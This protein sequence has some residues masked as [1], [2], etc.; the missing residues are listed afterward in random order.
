MYVLRLLQIGEEPKRY[1]FA[2]TLEGYDKSQTATVSFEFQLTPQDQ[3]DL[4]WYLEDYLQ[5]PLD[6]ARKIAA[7]I[8]IFMRAIGAELFKAVFQTNDD[9]RTLW[10]KCRESLSDTRIEILLKGQE[11]I[12]LP[13]ELLSDA[14]TGTRLALQA[15]SFVRVN[16]LAEN[17]LLPSTDSTSIRILLVICRPAADDDVPFRSVA[18]HMLRG[19]SEKAKAHFQLDVLRPATFERLEQV[20]QSKKEAGTPYH[21]VHFDGH[22]IYEQQKQ[23]GFLLFENAAIL[24][25]PIYIHGEL[26]GKTLKTAGVPIAVLNACRSAHVE[27]LAAPSLI[28][29]E[30]NRARAFGSLADELIEAGIL[31]VVAMRYNIYVATAAQFVADLYSQLM[32][33]YLLGEAVTAVRTALKPARAAG[34]GSADVATPGLVCT[35]RL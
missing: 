17:Y 8:E 34:G 15:R 25:G 11:A 26:L 2:I 27:P 29:F 23:R 30:S 6:P 24:G 35:R 9:V 13:W 7:R 18:S 1:N 31:G 14:E 20:L 12:A 4:R 22:G 10:A 16:R 19:L 21:I 33:G 28:T 3:E 5:F 32:Q